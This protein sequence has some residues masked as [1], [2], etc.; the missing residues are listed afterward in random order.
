[1]NTVVLLYLEISVVGFVRY[2]FF[3][4]IFYSIIFPSVSRASQYRPFILSDDTVYIRTCFDTLRSH[5]AAAA[6]RI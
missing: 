3:S 6:V 5:T 2:V 4:F 1:M